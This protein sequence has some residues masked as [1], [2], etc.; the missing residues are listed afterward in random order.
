MP[1]LLSKFR[2]FLSVVYR[3]ILFL[4]L[5]QGDNSVVPRIVA[6]KSQLQSLTLRTLEGAKVRS[7]AK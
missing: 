2:I 5:V 3:L 7:R 4:L 6:L 1:F